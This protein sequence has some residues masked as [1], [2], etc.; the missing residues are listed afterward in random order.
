MHAHDHLQLLFDQ[1]NADLQHMM[2][3]NGHG[4]MLGS[5]GALG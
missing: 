5:A 2:M 3:E 1:V 4:N